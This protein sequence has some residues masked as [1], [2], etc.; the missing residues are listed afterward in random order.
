MFSEWKAGVD[1]E[2][3][4]AL[5]QEACSLFAL[6][7]P[8]RALLLWPEQVFP[9]GCWSFSLKGTCTRLFLGDFLTVLPFG[10][11]LLILEM[12]SSLP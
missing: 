5:H 11:G 2:A 4:G 9:S 3:A 1:S 8:Q 6:S 10:L 7:T 12:D